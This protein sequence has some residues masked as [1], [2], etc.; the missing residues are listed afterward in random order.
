MRLGIVGSR[1]FVDYPLL[2]SIVDNYVKQ[3]N[4]KVEK[5]VSGGAKGTD[6]LAAKYASERGYHLQEF[7]PDYGRFGRGAPLQRNTSIVENS[8]IILAFVTPASKGTW[9]TI[10]KAQALSKIVKIYNV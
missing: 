9:D 8:D 10:R 7:K 3:S 4:I 5:I 2:A 6:S 1:E